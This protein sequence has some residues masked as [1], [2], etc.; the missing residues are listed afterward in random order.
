MYIWDIENEKT[1]NNRMGRYKTKC[2]SDFIN[3]YAK[4][5]KNIL[6]VGGGSGR[7]AIP[8]HKDGHKVTVIDKNNEALEI[9]NKR[10]SEIDCISDDFLSVILGAG[11]KYEMIIAVEVLLYITDW[12]AF[13]KKVYRLLE[14]DGIFI[15]T[16]TNKNSWRTLLRKSIRY[17][18][19]HDDY[20]YTILSSNEYS[21]LIRQASFRI[22]RVNGF[23][24]LPC[25]LDSNS[26]F[27]KV[28]SSVEKALL[29][30]HYISQSPWLLY[31]VKKNY[32]TE[33]RRR[34]VN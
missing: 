13:F 10:C 17:S 19:N 16:A 34:P 23:S 20:E 1:Y 24:W 2:E 11:N 30:K 28:F 25:K 33:V 21:N 31:A 18:Q 3:K 8:L 7:F 15:F 12:P 14:D 9:L 27:V 22:E 5:P 4:K 32:K 26:I 29:L 6:D